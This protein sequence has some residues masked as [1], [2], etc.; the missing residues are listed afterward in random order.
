MTSLRSLI[1]VICTLPVTHIK[2]QPAAQI[3]AHKCNI[4]QMEAKGLYYSTI[5][6][7][8]PPLVHQRLAP[9]YP[10]HDGFH[11]E[12]RYNRGGCP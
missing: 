12:P 1:R 6:V 11:A 2:P 4:S 9:D 3:P 7:H 8:F 10:K 5:A